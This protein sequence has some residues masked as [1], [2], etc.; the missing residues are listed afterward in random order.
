MNF[1]FL[2]RVEV[3]NTDLGIWAKNTKKPIPE[4]GGPIMFSMTSE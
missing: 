2:L 3:K 1:L 4:K